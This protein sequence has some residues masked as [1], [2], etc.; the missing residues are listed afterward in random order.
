MIMAVR[1]RSHRHHVAGVAV[2]VVALVAAGFAIA[3]DTTINCTYTT[4][5]PT[6]V[7]T[8]SNIASVDS[9]QTTPLASN[10][11]D[12]TV[13]APN[14]ELTIT[15]DATQ[16]SVVA[17]QDIDYTIHVVNSGDVD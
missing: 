5:D 2:S 7:G 15:K 8:Y 6:D 17:G 11:A 3:E 16:T 14:P 4:V 1:P 9:D 13:T 12:V 10:Q